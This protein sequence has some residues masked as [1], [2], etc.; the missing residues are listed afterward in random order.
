[1]KAHALSFRGREAEPGIEK[2]CCVRTLRRRRLWIP[3]S[4]A[5]PRNDSVDY[6]A[7]VRSSV[8]EASRTTASFWLQT[9][10][11]AMS[12]LVFPSQTA[13]CFSSRSSSCASSP[14]TTTG[15]SGTVEGTAAGA[16]MAAARRE[17]SNSTTTIT[18]ISAG[19]QK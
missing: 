19:I 16:A 4:P 13:F 2:H 17:R 14:G 7:A 12:R 18:E 5:A 3:G 1:M 10:C 15:G 11:R 6:L 9:F 8:E